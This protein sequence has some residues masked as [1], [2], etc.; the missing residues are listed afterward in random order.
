[1]NIAEEP[2]LVPESETIVEGHMAITLHSHLSSTGILIGDT[3]RIEAG[4]SA[5]SQGVRTSEVV[6]APV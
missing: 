1:M 2:G 5:M 3:L 4:L 6:N